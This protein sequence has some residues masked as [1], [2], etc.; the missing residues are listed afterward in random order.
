M[1]ASQLNNT[2]RS[3]TLAL[4]AVGAA[5]VAVVVMRPGG[6]QA[7]RFAGDAA[8]RPDRRTIRPAG[9]RRQDDQR[10]DAARTAISGLFRIY[11]LPR[12]LPDRARAH[13]RHSD[14]DGRQVYPCLVHHGRSAARHAQD[15]GWTTSAASTPASS[16]FPEARK[17][18]KRRRRPI[19]CSPARGSRSP[20]ATIPWT[21]VRSSILM[22][23]TGA[24]VEAFNVER[25]PEEAAKDLERF[26]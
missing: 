4:L 25:P 19:G 8:R 2:P 24:F 23:K 6:A 17:R 9:R 13:L 5:V 20:T 7:H 18:S 21:T 14:P 12:R 22:D 26:L 1:P 10:S 11:P 15:H 16:A 3:R